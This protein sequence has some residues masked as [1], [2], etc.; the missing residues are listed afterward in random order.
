VFFR[1]VQYPYYGVTAVD[2]AYYQTGYAIS[3][4]RRESEEYL[5]PFLVRARKAG[6][7][8]RAIVTIGSPAARLLDEVKSLPRPIIVMSTR[9]ASGIKRWVLGSVTDKVVRSSGLPV[10]VVP[11]AGD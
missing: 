10:L 7:P 3:Q 9:G 1:S 11:P 4:Q 5:E 6:V 8:G 2:A